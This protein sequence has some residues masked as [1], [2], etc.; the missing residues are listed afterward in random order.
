MLYYFRKKKS[1]EVVHTVYEELLTNL[2][3]L[4][5]RTTEKTSNF[6][7]SGPMGY[8][9]N[10]HIAPR[11]S[12][13]SPVTGGTSCKFRSA[14]QDRLMISG[15]ADANLGAGDFTAESRVFLKSY[16]SNAST[17]TNADDYQGTSTWYDF[18]NSAK[19]YCIW[20]TTTNT[21]LYVS[22]RV[23]PLMAWAEIAAVRR[24]GYIYVYING[25]LDGAF[26]C[27]NNFT[28]GIYGSIMVGG[29]TYGNAGNNFDGYISSIHHCKSAKYSGDYTPSRNA[30]MVAGPTT[31]FLL[32][33]DSNTFIDEAG[34]SAVWG[35]GA[36]KTSSAVKKFSKDSMVFDGT[37]YI[38]CDPVSLT[39][40]F[41]VSIWLHPTARTAALTPIISQWKQVA[42]DCG[43]EITLTTTGLPQFWFGAVNTAAAM[44][45]GTVAVPLNVWS[46]LTVTRC[47][48]YFVMYLNGAVIATYTGAVTL[49]GRFLEN[50]NVVLGNCIANTGIP[51]GAS[52][53]YFKGYMD[54]AHIV[55]DH[56]DV[57]GPY[58]VP[59]DYEPTGK[60]ITVTDGDPYYSCTP[61]HLRFNH[62]A[63]ATV[64]KLS[65]GKGNSIGNTNITFQEVAGFHY[66]TVGY[67][68]GTSYASYTRVHQDIA[69]KDFAI[70][71]DFAFSDRSG[72]QYLF[73]FGFGGYGPCVAKNANNKI[74]FQNIYGSTQ[75]TSDV[76]IVANKV[77]HIAI[78]RYA[79]FTRLFIDGVM[80]G[81]RFPDTTT[82]DTKVTCYIGNTG[83]NT[84][85][86][87]KGWIS[88]F[89]VTLMGRYKRDFT[90]RL[91]AHPTYW[92]YVDD[93]DWSRSVTI[94]AVTNARHVGNRSFI[95]HADKSQLSITGSPQQG[96]FSPFR[97]SFGVYFSTSASY[98]T[99][100]KPGLSLGA[101]DF[102]AKFYGRFD[103]I[104]SSQFVATL[105]GNGFVVTVSGGQ[106]L[107]YVSSTGA[108]WN[109]VNG[110]PIINVL[111]KNRFYD[112]E[113][114][115]TGGKIYTLVDG[116]LTS[117]SNVDIDAI[118]NDGTAGVTVGGSFAGI[119]SNFRLDNGICLHTSEYESTF[120]HLEAL[121]TTVLLTAQSSYLKDNSD[122]DAAIVRI[123]TPMVTPV[124]P[125]KQ[126]HTP[127]QGKSSVSF[128]SVSGKLSTA[129]DIKYS[130]GNTFE[131]EGYLYL[132]ALPAAS[133]ECRFLMIGANTSQT[134]FAFSVTA[135]GQIK[136]T[137][138]ATGAT[139]LITAANAIVVG[140][141]TY[142]T[143][144]VLNGVATIYK[145]GKAIA[146]G[147]MT[148]QTSGPVTLTVG[149]DTTASF[150]ATLNGAIADFRIST[151]AR[152]SGDFVPPSN[153]V[154]TDGSTVFHLKGDECIAYE[155]NGF[156][157]LDVF[158]NV[159]LQYDAPD[160]GS[161]LFDGGV[162]YIRAPYS[163]MLLSIGAGDFTVDLTF[164]LAVATATYNEIFAIGNTQIRFGNTGFSYYLQI[165]NGT[166]TTYAWS[167]LYTQTLCLKSTIN[168][169]MV[170]RNG[171][172][173]FYVNGKITAIAGVLFKADPTAVL[174]TY[175]QLG[176][177]ST[178]G[179][180]S[181]LIKDFKLSHFARHCGNFLP[182][183]RRLAQA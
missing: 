136:A 148:T 149:Y 86:G 173:T 126:L 80:Q 28:T 58:T 180:F 67:F 81:V 10:A 101:A 108:S 178:V 30:Q 168:V 116:S 45:A 131:I 97:K 39:G 72:N 172:F 84:S 82:Y 68:T 74:I 114:G 161:F 139:A 3:A 142:I 5:L 35:S 53:S 33:F 176:Y 54:D 49:N 36:T 48:E 15:N 93:N 63:G 112:I 121:P 127:G 130:L 43:W 138:P 182:P 62:P 170:R 22:N 59:T 145:R 14:Q 25:T 102:T 129:A 109:L 34:K 125:V 123:G 78:S 135:T 11:L 153:P 100:Y 64:A 9:V 165:V 57:H 183:I 147:A 16:N 163:P 115:R 152:K 46:R 155:P 171:V 140:E 2:D 118:Y 52:V 27:T 44:M 133:T 7:D 50:V 167:A 156:T 70:E 56:C 146:S 175:L 166:T 169:S 1:V 95:N 92:N 110:V 76:T 160:N 159:Q 99:T 164:N 83:N 181:G 144:T 141:W 150:A 75:I 66:P 113:I 65:D 41:R 179:P 73:D 79:G 154:A 23:I 98:T 94:N 18:I 104:A 37:N 122:S 128:D 32:T 55:K 89:R 69:N 90:P 105:S 88:D 174:A 96:G 40:D 24:N 158:G 91:S 19:K 85:L 47:G 61:V 42:A 71:G 103:D 26:A 107:L 17:I 117:V 137:V 120:D 4:L 124:C 13:K 87:L 77:Y 21:A 151:I 60:S 119:I 12:F 6:V 51:G 29:D 8:A 134:A 20:D 177:L 106:L 31:C 162:S 132:N 111:E 38:E 143:L 157:N